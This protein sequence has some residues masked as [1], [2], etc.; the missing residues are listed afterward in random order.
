VAASPP[1]VI[2]YDLTRYEWYARGE[3]LVHEGWS[4]SPGALV[5]ASGGE[6]EALGDYGGVTYYRRRDGGADSLFVP[7]YERYWLTFNPGAAAD[8]AAASPEGGT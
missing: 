4:Y 5:A 2:Y 8:T 6:M 1:P 3:P 7:V